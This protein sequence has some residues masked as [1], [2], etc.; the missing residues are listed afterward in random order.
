MTFFSNF[1]AGELLRAG[2]AAEFEVV[3]RVL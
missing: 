1:V 2:C 3:F